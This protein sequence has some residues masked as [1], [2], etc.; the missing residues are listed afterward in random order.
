MARILISSPDIII[1]EEPTSPLDLELRKDIWSSLYEI[2]KK[3]TTII[4]T[5]RK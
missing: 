2:L 5:H 1:M 3:F 4:I